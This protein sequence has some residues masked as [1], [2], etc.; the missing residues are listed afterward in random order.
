MKLL[1]FDSETTG[2]PKAYNAS[3]T[4]VD[5]WPRV[6]AL[7]FSLCDEKGNV[8]RERH[9]LIRPDGWVMPTEEFWVTN[10][11]S[12]EKS[13][14]QGIPITEA[15]KDF[16]TA[17]M[18][19]DVLI[20]HNINFDH[21]IVWAEF[22]RAGIPPRSGMIKF[23]TMMKSPK[24]CQIPNKGRGGYKWPTLGELY[25]TLF[26]KEIR[27]AHD[28]MGDV[29]SCRDSFFELVRLGVVNIAELTEPAS[30]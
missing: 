12:Q 15:L 4:D 23:C 24:F 3:Y 5:N 16:M 28:A 27:D 1:F 14:A 18:E 25:Q 22:V 19:A 29:K 2:K 30:V 17:K 20:A 6:I 21:R 10:G 7:A 13:M 11:F 9:Y 8:L 26:K